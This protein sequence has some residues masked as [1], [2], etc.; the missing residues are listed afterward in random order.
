MAQKRTGAAFTVRF[1]RNG[2]KIEFDRIIIKSNGEGTALF[3]IIDPT[4]GAVAPD[5]T[6]ADDQPIIRLSPRTASGFGVAV[7]MVTWKVN[8]TA[9]SF[10]Y[11]GANWVWAGGDSTSGYQARINSGNYELKICKNLATPTSTSAKTIEYEINY[12]SGNITETF[13][14]SV[15]CPIYIAG[16]NSH[17]VQITVPA[18]N[19][20]NQTGGITLGNY[21]YWDGS[22]WNAVQIGSTT[23]SAVCY[24]GTSAVTIGQNDYTMQWYKDGVAISGA[25]SSQL[26]VNRDMVEGGSVFIAKLLKNG[27]VVGQ[28]GQRINDNADEWQVQASP[29]SAATNVVSVKKD[30]SGTLVQQNAVYD[31]VL[32]KNGDLAQGITPTFTSQIFN[33]LGVL[34]GTVTGSS[35]T[36]TPAHCLLNGSQS[37]QVGSPDA[38]YDDVDVQVT[39]VFNDVPNS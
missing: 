6:V 33:A 29:Q 15:E 27:A 31:L 20:T 4:S 37:I 3:Q 16:T 9:L 24:Y 22:Q 7:N 19:V 2:D 23:L 39:A 36:I 26:T 14:D 35:V 28:D 32:T 25:T 8:G 1:L 34:M 17:I 12:T 5:W 13:R 10:T 18:V 30:A 38:V 21:E 11:D